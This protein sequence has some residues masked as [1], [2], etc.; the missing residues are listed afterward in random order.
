MRKPAWGGSP[1]ADDEAARERI[2]EA[3]KRAVLRDGIANTSVASIAREAQIT[4]QTFYRYF[5]DGQEVL[6][7][8]EMRA[9]GGLVEALVRHTLSF[10]VLDERLAEGLLFLAREVPK[11]PLLS[12]HFEG[13]HASKVMSDAALDYAA[14]YVRTIWTDAYPKPTKAKARLLAELQLRVLYSLVVQPRGGRELRRF[15]DGAVRPAIRGWL[16]HQAR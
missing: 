14:D 15:V 7:D 11:D 6:H 10:E 4:R 16:E 9:G 5:A 1:P 12:R 13:A 3:A 8:A 2:L